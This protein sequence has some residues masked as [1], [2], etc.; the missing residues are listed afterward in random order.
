VGAAGAELF[1]Y[2]IKSPYE[3]RQQ[4]WMQDVGDAIAD[5]RDRQG[6]D[7]EALRRDP[8]FTDT[9][10]EATQ[11][12]LRTSDAEKHE[13]LRNAIRNTAVSLAPE[14]AQ[15]QMFIR[16]IDELTGWHLRLLDL[17][18]DP[19]AWAKR[20]GVRLPDLMAGSLSSIVEA[21]FPELR[22]RRDLY[23]QWWRDLHTRGLVN[24]QDLHT[25]M[26]GSGLMSARTSGLGDRFLAFVRAPASPAS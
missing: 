15:R 18:Q 20:T 11:A 7:V 23:D 13:A 22:T 14:A 19:Q 12:A 8:A 16:F 26:S 5:L 17:F 1:E 4:K 6:V 21:A 10:M 9:V 24:T 25:M 2:V 3:A